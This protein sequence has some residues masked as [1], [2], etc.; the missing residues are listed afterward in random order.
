MSP[1]AVTL[2][3]RATA[4]AL[5]CALACAQGAAAATVDLRT[6]YGGSYGI[7]LTSLKEARFRTTVPQQ[8]DFSCGSAA[9]ATLLTF[10]YGHPVGEAEVFLAMYRDGDQAKIRREG[11]SLLDIRRYLLALGYQADGFELPLDKLFEEGLPAIVLLNDRGYRH[12]VVVK[13]LRKG[14]VLIGDPARGTRAMSRANFERLWDNRVLFVVHNRREVALFNQP[15]DWRTAP[16]AP[17]DMGI[18][19]EGL[20]NT[21]MPRRGPGDI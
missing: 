5:L 15:R 8:Y 13:G 14:R 1:V 20:Q 9:A 12:F 21:V 2:R 18:S 17:L 10:Q 16:P 4:C 11:F 19:R 7:R 6:P 3:A